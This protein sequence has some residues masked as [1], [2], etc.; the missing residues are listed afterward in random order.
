MIILLY[1]IIHR[2][3]TVTHYINY[4]LLYFD[5]FF[6]FNL[7]KPLISLLFLDS[8]RDKIDPKSKSEGELHPQKQAM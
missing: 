1:I 4:F 8:A 2:V 3:F 6:F 5:L 7:Q